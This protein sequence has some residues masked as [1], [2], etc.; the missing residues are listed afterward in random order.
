MQIINWHIFTNIC[1]LDS[2]YGSSLNCKHHTT[3]WRCL[4]TSR[5]S[6]SPGRA[7]SHDKTEFLF[8]DESSYFQTLWHSALEESRRHQPCWGGTECWLQLRA[9]LSRTGWQVK[10]KGMAP[11]QAG[12]RHTSCLREDTRPLE[13]AC[14]WKH[15]QSG[16]PW[17]QAAAHRPWEQWFS[18]NWM[19]A[20]LD[21]D[22]D[23]DRK[24]WTG[25]RW[26]AH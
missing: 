15:W 20:G 8:G 13:A 21:F 12:K 18:G 9:S 22:S 14:V 19:R 7:N 26:L 4:R 11:R 23:K 24:S 5:C 25:E 1:D 17:L 16:T 2:Q 6:S 3:L 10:T